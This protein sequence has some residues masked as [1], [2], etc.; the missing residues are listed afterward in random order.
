MVKAPKKH[1]VNDG[2]LLGYNQ[3]YE[4]SAAKSCSAEHSGLVENS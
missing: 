2:L 1:E 4:G 3:Q